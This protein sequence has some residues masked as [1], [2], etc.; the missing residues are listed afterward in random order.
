MLIDNKV[1]SRYASLYDVNEVPVRD[2]FSGLKFLQNL[3]ADDN[4]SNF[5]QKDGEHI[6]LNY[7][8]PKINTKSEYTHCPQNWHNY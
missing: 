2:N 6:I 8:K 4:V 1:K 5:L 3:D 7:Y